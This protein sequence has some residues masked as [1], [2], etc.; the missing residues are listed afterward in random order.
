MTKYIKLSLLLLLFF[1]CNNY[2]IPNQDA[3]QKNKCSTNREMFTRICVCGAIAASLDLFLNMFCP[4]KGDSYIVPCFCAALTIAQSILPS[5]NEIEK[6]TGG[7][8]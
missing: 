8:L 3:K 4:H 1:T 6:N 5:D 2:T 7:T